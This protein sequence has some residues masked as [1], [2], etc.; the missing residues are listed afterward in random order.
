MI[1]EVAGDILLTKAQA[2]AHGVAPNDQFDSGTGSGP[3]RAMAGAGHR[4][5]RH[6]MV[7]CSSIDRAAPE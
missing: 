2:V 1:H 4:R 3:S 6:G 7:R 5:G